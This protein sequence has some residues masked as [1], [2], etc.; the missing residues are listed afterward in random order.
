M[1]HPLPPPARGQEAHEDEPPLKRFRGGG[2]SWDDL[3]GRSLPLPPPPPPRRGPSTDRTG[4]QADG[5]GGQ[6]LLPPPGMGTPGVTNGLPPPPGP[7]TSGLRLPPPPPP[8]PSAPTVGASAPGVPAPASTSRL[9]L[10]PPPPD[11]RPLT[12]STVSASAL[13]GEN[14]DNYLPAP[15]TDDF[16]EAVQ[17]IVERCVSTF[18]RYDPTHRLHV[19]SS[20]A[21]KMAA[22]MSAQIAGKERKKYAVNPAPVSRPHLEQKIK[23][24][25]REHVES[26]AARRAG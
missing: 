1:H 13:N 24:H 5:P 8:R 15:P 11:V 18:R 9:G 17:E 4:L 21:E 2:G 23:H 26:I 14:S 12:P 10:P 20:H 3:E 16:M 7:P 22:K 6:S 19:K 25:V